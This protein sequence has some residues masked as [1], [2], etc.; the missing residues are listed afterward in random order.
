MRTG[1]PRLQLAVASLEVA[2][3]EIDG[4]LTEERPDDRERLFEPVDSMVERKAERT[5]FR[6]VPAGAEPED[7]PPSRDLVHRRR[8]LGEHGRGVKCR[9]CDQ[10]AEANAGRR[11]GNRREQ[12]PDFPGT[13][14]RA[15]GEPI[16]EM[17]ADPDRV[18]AQVLGTAGHRDVLGPMHLALD[19]GQLDTDAE[20][21]I[22]VEG[23]NVHD[24][25]RGHDAYRS[26][27]GHD[28][29]M[30][31]G[32]RCPWR[33]AYREPRVDSQA[34]FRIRGIMFR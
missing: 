27:V 32:R 28:S 24:G 12:R 13:A 30:W 1:R 19:L 10:R 14:S 29:G 4:A 20:W 16:Q 11:R 17:V 2:A 25:Y 22:H 6:I 7:E 5:E 8:E 21:A 23:R 31:S 15:V 3:V 33:R 26:R 18:E 34:T 9:G